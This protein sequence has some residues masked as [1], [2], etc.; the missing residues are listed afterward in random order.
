MREVWAEILDGIGCKSCLIVMLLMTILILITASFM[1]LLDRKELKDKQNQGSMYIP[2]SPLKTTQT[3]F[4][5]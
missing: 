3:N 5:P 2:N 1:C 4:T